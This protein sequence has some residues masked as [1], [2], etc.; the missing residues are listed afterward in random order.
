MGV[1]REQADEC[2]YALL[3]HF[4]VAAWRAKTEYYALR[5]FGASN[6]RTGKTK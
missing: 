1:T 6:Y 3:R 4:G 2:Y 5:M